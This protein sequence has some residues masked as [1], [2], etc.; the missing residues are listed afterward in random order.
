MPQLTNDMRE[1]E[2]K[3]QQLQTQ[4]DSSRKHL[5]DKASDVFI[6]YQFLVLFLFQYNF[7]KDVCL[8]V[9]LSWCCWSL[10]ASQIEELQGKL[11][12]TELELEE[13]RRTAA[14]RSLVDVFDCRYVSEVSCSHVV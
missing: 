14:V 8:L 3:V 13:E 7:N 10:Q 5:K 1:K 9:L 6:L 4:V 2:A 12:Q 11:R